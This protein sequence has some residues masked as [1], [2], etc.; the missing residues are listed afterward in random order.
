MRP[1]REAMPLP[2]ER[3]DQDQESFVAVR[4]IF[5]DSSNRSRGTVSDYVF[6]LPRAVIN[7]AAMELTGFALPT[8]LTPTFRAGVNDWIDFRLSNGLTTKTFATQLP[9]NSYTYQNVAVPYLDLLRVVEK[10]LGFAIAL[11][12]DF[13]YGAALPV[14]FS[15]EPDPEQHVVVS[16]TN[17]ILTLL[18]GTGVNVSRSA[19]KPLGFL[20]QDYTVP[21]TVRLRAP[22]RA[23]L[24]PFRKIEVWID[25]ISESYPVAVVYN[26]NAN[27][28]GQVLNENHARLRLLDDAPP[29]ILSRLTMRIRVD[30]KPV[31]D[32]F[33]NEHS[34]SF[35][36]FAFTHT[37]ASRKW[38]RQFNTM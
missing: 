34:L 19:A 30:G 6:E 37:L 5:V 9:S 22:L 15:T 4:R 8:S 12:P 27:Y 36:L 17:A 2:R 26:T 13:G 7:V 1:V 18:F 20:A 29:R 10:K 28:Y 31:E 25:E 16:C 38:L 23:L 24:E 3:F 14:V 21:A 35:T 11:D 32:A 33:K